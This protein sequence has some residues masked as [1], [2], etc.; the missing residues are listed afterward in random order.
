MAKN[1]TSHPTTYGHA[2]ARN[3]DAGIVVKIDT[4]QPVEFADIGIAFTSIANQYHRFCVSKGVPYDKNRIFIDSIHPGSIE[5]RLFIKI[6]GAMLLGIDSPAATVAMDFVDYFADRILSYS[7]Q[8]GRVQDITKDE[9]LDIERIA[10]V[11]AKDLKGSQSVT[12][13]IYEH[14]RQDGP[15]IERTT[16]TFNF[17]SPEACTIVEETKRHRIEKANQ[18]SVEEM[19]Q[20]VQN[21]NMV[22]KRLDRDDAKLDQPSGE[23]AIVNSIA[24]DGLRLIYG[25]AEAKTI[26]K[27]HIHDSDGNV[28]YTTFRVDLQ[29]IWR[30]RKRWAYRVTHVHKVINNL[31]AETQTLF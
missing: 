4:E 27:R 24:P 19:Q 7:T 23:Y 1:N 30:N 28:L 12:S 13:V 16:A 29:V 10:T 9:L 17:S 18:P 14:S 8:K 31:P 6:A 21:V 5:V 25:D 11:V 15:L 2:I 3:G 22:F 20:E 26:I